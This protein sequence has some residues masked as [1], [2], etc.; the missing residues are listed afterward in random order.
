MTRLYAVA[1]VAAVLLG[2]TLNAAAADL[3]RLASRTW[4]WCMVHSP[5]APAGKP[6]RIQS[7]G[8]R[9]SVA[10]PEDLVRRGHKYTKAAIDG[11]RRADRLVGHRYGG[12]VCGA[13]KAPNVTALVYISA[14]ALDE[15][16][17]SAAIASRAYLQPVRQI[18]KTQREFFG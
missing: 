11:T 5:M 17:S 7:D 2:G 16:E 15:G 14:F 13:G 3:R 4:S 9:V 1:A 12:I 6:E 18:G 8:Y 10:P